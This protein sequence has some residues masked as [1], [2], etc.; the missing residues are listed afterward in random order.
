MSKQLRFALLDL[1][2]AHDRDAMCAAYRKL[3]S[4]ELAAHEREVMAAVFNNLFH[5][6]AVQA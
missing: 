5:F 3:E 4:A 1:I 6:W 2:W